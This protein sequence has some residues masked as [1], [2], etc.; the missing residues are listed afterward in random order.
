VLDDVTPRWAKVGAA[1]KKC[2][3]GPGV[4][5]EFLLDSRATGRG[6]NQSA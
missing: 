2:D 5:L 1:L 3:A 6:L 4:A